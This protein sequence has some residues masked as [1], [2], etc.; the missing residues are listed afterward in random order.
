MIGRRMMSNGL[1][2]RNGDRFRHRSGCADVNA[3]Q[4]TCTKKMKDRKT[5]KT[6]V[7]TKIEVCRDTE[8]KREKDFSFISISRP[9]QRCDS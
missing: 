1:A 4:D 9:W 5:E 6:T 2:D 3:H 8:R 7:R